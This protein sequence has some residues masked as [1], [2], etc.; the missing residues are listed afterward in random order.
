VGDA[1]GDS[2]EVKFRN[3]ESEVQVHASCVG[4]VPRFEVESEGGG[5]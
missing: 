1:S 3:S 5:E 4:G 2:V